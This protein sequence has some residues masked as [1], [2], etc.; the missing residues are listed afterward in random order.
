MKLL[1]NQKIFFHFCKK[2]RKNRFEN[3]LICTKKID[4]EMNIKLKFRE[5]HIIS[6]KLFFDKNIDN[7]KDLFK[8]HSK[9]ITSY[10]L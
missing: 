1:N 6:K 9:L 8:N 5:K 2:Y 7:E 10:I 4:F 3:A